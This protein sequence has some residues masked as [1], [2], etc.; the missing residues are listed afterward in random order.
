MGHR[1]QATGKQLTHYY[2]QGGGEQEHPSQLAIH[3]V[4]QQEGSHQFDGGDNQL[5]QCACHSI[6][7]GGYVGLQPGSDITRMQRLFIVVNPATQQMTEDAQAHLGGLIGRGTDGGVEI[8]LAQGDI[9]SHHQY[10]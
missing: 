3:R 4:K 1:A 9:A 10:E 5:R 8:Q 6:T 7:D 2:Q